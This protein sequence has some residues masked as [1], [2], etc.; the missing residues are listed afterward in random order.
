MAA[1]LDCFLGQ[2]DD[3]THDK[4]P[5][6]VGTSASHE[7]YT[8]V[9]LPIIFGAPVSKTDE[10]TAASILT[11]LL[12]AEKPS[13]SLNITIN[14]IVAQS[15]GWTERIAVA[16]LNAVQNII[17]EGS[18]LREA[19]KDAYEK[20]L[21]AA[22]AVLGFARDHPVLTGVFCVVIALGIL[23][24]LAPA[25]IHALGFGILG[26][27]EGSWAAAW[28]SSVYGGTVRAGSLFSYLQ[29]LGML[30]K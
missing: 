26:P 2:A 18:P 9:K 11:T 8:L 7:G 23:M 22:A 28:Q 13:R 20:A 12:T 10:E 15:G 25:V 21:D 6:C 17:K 3:A 1:L 16:I 24:L 27:V 30:Y 29:K 4:Q 14:D 19:M 5:R